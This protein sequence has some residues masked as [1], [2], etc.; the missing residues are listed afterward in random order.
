LKGNCFWQGA[1]I[2]RKTTTFLRWKVLC[3]DRVI[4]SSDRKSKVVRMICCKLQQRCTES[5]PSFKCENIKKSKCW[6]KGAVRGD[7]W[8]KGS[9]GEWTE[10]NAV[11]SF[12]YLENK[13]YDYSVNTQFT[14]EGYGS[15]TTGIVVKSKKSTLSAGMNGRIRI[16]GVL[17]K[18]QSSFYINYHHGSFEIK[19]HKNPTSKIQ[20]TG[21]SGLEL[22]FNW[23]KNKKLLVIH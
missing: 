8:V 12:V 1:K 19:K 15:I 16:N 4:N 6:W 5:G 10:V 3:R 9:N 14:K 22:S 23:E 13:Q 7:V 20:V 11:G 17:I 21:L 18:G 2:K